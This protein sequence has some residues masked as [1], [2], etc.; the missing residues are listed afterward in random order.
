[1]KI[2][3]SLFT[4]LPKFGERLQN[5]TVPV[6]RTAMLVCVVDNLQTYKVTQRRDFPAHSSP[7]SRCH[8]RLICFPH[9]VH[10]P[11]PALA[12]APAR[13]PPEWKP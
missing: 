3:L 5:I 9:S 10:R 1:M 8:L 4:D 7:C 2:Y 12:V 6:G 13:A 11:A